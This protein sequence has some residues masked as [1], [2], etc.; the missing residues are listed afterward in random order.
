[1][2]GETIR[3]AVRLGCPEATDADIDSA[4]EAAALTGPQANLPQGPE[5]PLGEEGLGLSGGQ[6]QRLALARALIRE[7]SVL[8]LDEVSAAL[9]PESEAKILE[10]IRALPAE[11]TIISVTH[12]LL[13]AQSADLI[14]VLDSDEIVEDGRHEELLAMG[15]A[16]A[17]LYQ[18]QTG[19]TTDQGTVKVTPEHLAMIP[20]LSTNSPAIL[21][22]FAQNQGFDVRV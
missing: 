22:S 3:E 21:E 10:T 15:G 16:Y 2:I 4:L 8:I 20:I 18:H 9:D 14:L 5:T 13:F 12:R 6:K 7:P 11:Q 1:M 19:F 17:Q